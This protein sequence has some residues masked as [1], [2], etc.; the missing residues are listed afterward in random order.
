[1]SLSIE[2][3]RIYPPD[4]VYWD[5]YEIYI[6]TI[7]ERYKEDIKY[8]QFLNEP[9]GKRFLGR[10]EQYAEMYKHTWE[11]L[12]SVD[13]DAKIVGLC[14]KSC[15][16]NLEWEYFDTVSNSNKKINLG[17]WQNALDTLIGLIGLDSIDVISHHI[18]SSPENFIEWTK[19]LKN[20]YE[21][22][23]IWITET[24]FLHAD[25]VKAERG[26]NE[27]CTNCFLPFA[28]YESN[29]GE[30]FY[31][32]VCANWKGD[33]ACEIRIDTFLN[34]N[35]TVILYNREKNG[36]DTIIYNGGPLIY[37]DTIDTIIALDIGD[38]LKV[39]D[40]WAEE[41]GITHNPD[42]QAGN[43]RQLFDSIINN[44]NFL[45]NLKIFFYCVDNTMH[46]L[47]YPP[48]IGFGNWSGE[49]NTPKR[50]ARQH[51]HAVYSIIDTE[52]TPYLAYDVLK[53]RMERISNIELQNVQI[54]ADSTE[55]YE[56]YYSIRTGDSSSYFVID[57]CG[58]VTMTAGNHISLTPGYEAKK[59]SEFYASIDTLLEG[60]N[61]SGTSSS[62]FSSVR[63]KKP[64]KTSPKTSE[65]SVS[66][67]EKIPKVFSCKQNFP[68]PFASST[69]IK[70]GL[71]KEANVKL[72]IFNLTGQKVHTLIDK[73]QTAGYKLVSWNGTTSSGVRLPQGVYFYTLKAGDEFERKYKMILLK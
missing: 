3:R 40:C 58:D 44:P 14:M 10:P 45:D 57:S 2:D 12:K 4:S 28:K 55:S 6:S 26:T 32:N 50:Y 47:Y 30:A 19:E 35:D 41:I 59:G 1:M 5:E 65:E 43:Y 39:Y 49:T 31:D 15:E 8:W 17:S 11:A 60:G 22:K 37:K 33:D 68:N 67:K 9:W 72:E 24:G 63:H 29:T 34:I 62:N 52:G 46:N 21:N 51:K 16:G 64:K 20:I 27:Y 42:S 61:T 56:A 25:E 70:Y 69:L 13:P 54:G 53:H 71:P 18:Y 23:P 73:K 66:E 7:L 36:K 48:Q 38:T